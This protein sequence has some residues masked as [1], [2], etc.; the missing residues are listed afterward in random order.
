M[1]KMLQRF[2]EMHP[3]IILG[4]IR[5]HT[6]DFR[7][8]DEE[9]QREKEEKEEGAEEKIPQRAYLDFVI[10]FKHRVIIL[11]VDENQHRSYPAGCDVSR[12]VN[13][14]SSLHMGSAAVGADGDER[15]T[16]VQKVRWIRYNPNGYSI[17]GEK[18][19][20]STKKREAALFDLILKEPAQKTGVVFAYYDAD[21]DGNTFCVKEEA[22]FQQKV[23]ADLLE[24]AI[25]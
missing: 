19:N 2:E 22:A 10:W 11:E 5:E 18:Q 8:L 17:G 4:W 9:K 12:M 25:L 14:M 20:T 13:V 21:Y 23:F 6:I 15:A 7:C 24:P 1:E 3:G 16:A